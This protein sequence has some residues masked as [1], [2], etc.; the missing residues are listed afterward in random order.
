MILDT[1]AVSAL[2]KDDPNIQPVLIAAAHQLALPV[3]VI[4]EYRY[5]IAQSKQSA[6]LTKWLEAFIDDCAVLDV[7]IETTSHYAAISTELR[8]TGKPIPD[9]DL[10]IAA[11]CRQHHLP[12]VSRDRHFDVVPGLK[13]LDW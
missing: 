11:L 1:N 8:K 10:W 13:R 3:I 4:G 5:G 6:S 12:L 2:A 9:N 7:V